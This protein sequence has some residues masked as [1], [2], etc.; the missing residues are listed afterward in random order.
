MRRGDFPYPPEKAH[1]KVLGKTRWRALAKPQALGA[2][3]TH[4]HPGDAHPEPGEGEHP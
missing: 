2:L 4:F 1:G 3:N